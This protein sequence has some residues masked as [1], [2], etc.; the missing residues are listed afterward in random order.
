M[1]KQII[2]NILLLVPMIVAIVLFFGP[3]PYRPIALSFCPACEGLW[4]VTML[5]LYVVLAVL[6]AVLRKWFS[7]LVCLFAGFCVFIYRL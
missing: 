4:G 7:V 3:S 2:L 5:L 1:I 6:F